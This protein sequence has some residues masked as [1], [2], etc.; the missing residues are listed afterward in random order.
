MRLKENQVFNIAAA[1]A[2]GD[3][4]K[5]M[6]GPQ[7][8]YKMLMNSL[9]DVVITNDGLK[10]MEELSVRHPATRL[11][12]AIA[13]T[14]GS[15]FGDGTKSAMVLAAELLSNGVKLIKRG[16][17]PNT[18]VA[19][20]RKALYEANRLIEEMAVPINI[21]HNALFKVASTAMSG[22][23]GEKLKEKYAGMLVEVLSYLGEKG[24][25]DRNDLL[26]FRM[27]KSKVKRDI[28]EGLI[29]K[30]ERAHP[31]MPG[32]VEK[33]RIAILT[34][35]VG[36]EKP[37]R[38]MYVVQDS[39]KEVL[40]LEK[41]L[42]DEQVKR[43]KELG[44]TAVFCSGEIDAWAAGSLARAGI[45]GVA[46]IR[47]EDLRKLAKATG[48][49]IVHRVKN[50]A[51]ED[52]GYAEMVEEFLRG[53]ERN[54]LIE[55]RG[56]VVTLLLSGPEERCSEIERVIR[57]AFSAML[58]ALES[59]IVP[60]GG[61]VEVE[62]ALR[63]RRASVRAGNREQMAMEAF[64]DAIEE[65]PKALARNAGQNSIDVL[66][67]LRRGHAE[68]GVN[69][70]I[71]VHGGV[72]DMVETG[73]LEPAKIKAQA[74]RIGTEVVCMVLRIDDNLRAFELKKESLPGVEV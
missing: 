63:L 10:V 5:S 42:I 56:R 23:I 9:G 39:Q 27:P 49:E 18:V 47:R 3:M 12:A 64:A 43:L 19:G 35:G 14:M 28:F 31:G 8:G 11:T 41:S 24:R 36:I 25:P 26:F 67:E 4:V 17:H 60:G 65:L 61:A 48:A 32:R 62:L 34:G 58:T 72:A 54:V 74:L 13:G 44:V 53:E 6:L 59:G 16:L 30:A 7:G 70:G 50:I 46:R 52:L 29:V 71:D 68:G 38:G 22:R 57:C 55:S 20:Y 73:V 37:M 69:L 45:L 21:D 33:C 15:E 1:K 66:V 2:M 51:P 40:E